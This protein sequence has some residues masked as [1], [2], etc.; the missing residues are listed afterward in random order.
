VSGPHQLLRIAKKPKMEDAEDAAPRDD[1]DDTAPSIGAPDHQDDD[2]DATP[3]LPLDD[4]DTLEEKPACMPSSQTDQSES[5]SG[6]S[7][8]AG[9]TLV[10]ETSTRASIDCTN[11]VDQEHTK[12]G[13]ANNDTDAEKGDSGSSQLPD[14]GDH[15]LQRRKSY[16]A[17]PEKPADDAEHGSQGDTAAKTTIVIADDGNDDDNAKDGSATQPSQGHDEA[18]SVPPSEHVRGVD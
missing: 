5:E 1:D 2:N 11:V 4:E 8:H 13:V 17:D 3:E 16:C 9:A 15:G 18:T 7:T 14:Q 10:A 12:E 6:A